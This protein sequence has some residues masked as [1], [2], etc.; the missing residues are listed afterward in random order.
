MITMTIGELIVK[1]QEYP[2][3]TPVLAREYNVGEGDDE[4]IIRVEPKPYIYC[5]EVFL[6]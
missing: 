4:Y 5:G 3:S 6:E 2:E 1:L